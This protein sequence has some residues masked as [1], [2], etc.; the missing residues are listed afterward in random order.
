MEDKRCIQCGV[1]KDISVFR[2]Y[3]NGKHGRQK[4]CDVC[5]RINNRYKYLKAKDALNKDQVDELV[6]L[7]ELFTLQKSRGLKPPAF[8]KRNTVLPLVT[9]MLD[10]LR[11]AIEIPEDIPTELSEWLTCDL[12]SHTVTELDEV[13]DTLTAKYRP[14]VGF[15]DETNVPIYDDTHR[16][17]LNT[18]IERFEVYEDSQD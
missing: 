5:E 2:P 1:L 16:S 12:A 11:S 3:Y 18:I 13:I 10:S 6:A 9:D 8:N 4:R 15:N 7:T 14:I 17:V